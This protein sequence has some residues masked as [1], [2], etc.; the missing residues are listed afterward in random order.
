MILRNLLIIIV[1]YAV[2]LQAALFQV[3]LP[4]LVLC[5]GENGHLAFEWQSKD[6][7]CVADDL[8]N[9]SIFY[10]SGEDI[11]NSEEINCTDINL[12]FHPSFAG[13]TKIINY[14][15][16]TENKSIFYKIDITESTKYF[17]FLNTNHITYLNSVLE[18]LQNTILII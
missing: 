9:Y 14:S 11:Y 1:S 15:K 7:Q 8:L 12:H 16:F 18:S 13:K 3:A 4:N 5:I 10:D 17:S 6:S 2:L